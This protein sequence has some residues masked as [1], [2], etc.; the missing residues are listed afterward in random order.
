MD[1]IGHA[2]THLMV[3]AREMANMLDDIDE[4]SEPGELL[5]QA[6]DV[7]GQAASTHIYSN[8]SVMT[9]AGQDKLLAKVEAEVTRQIGS[10][11]VLNRSFPK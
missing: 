2:I 5:R 4:S 10:P 6:A 1:G 7:L 8:P 3:Q 11:V 9:Y